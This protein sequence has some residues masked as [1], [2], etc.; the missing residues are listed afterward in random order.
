MNLRGYYNAR[1]HEPFHRPHGGLVTFIRRMPPLTLTQCLPNRC[2]NAHFRPIYPPE[3]IIPAATANLSNSSADPNT[4]RSSKARQR[5]S[6]IC[7]DVAQC[8]P[9]PLQR[10]SS[11]GTDFQW[12]DTNWSISVFF[13]EVFFDW[14]L[15]I[16]IFMAIY[17]TASIVLKVTIRFEPGTCLRAPASSEAG[18]PETPVR[19]TP[20]PTCQLIIWLN[21]V[22]TFTFVLVYAFDVT[23]RYVTSG[24]GRIGLL[25]Q[26]ASLVTHLHFTRSPKR[27]QIPTIGESGPHLSAYPVINREPRITLVASAAGRPVLSCWQQYRLLQRRS[28]TLSEYSKASLTSNEYIERPPYHHSILTALKPRI[29]VLTQG[30]YRP[31]IT[32]QRNLRNN[33]EVSGSVH[34]SS[35]HPIL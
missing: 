24:H 7:N 1:E 22:I 18:H 8:S 30:R 16:T 25:H 28:S 9:L 34:S 10:L 15:A 12:C 11:R 3:S 35:P 31:P 27:C 5:P 4:E 19:H 26:P 32:G 6:I 21:S 20:L 33:H 2:K 23:G 17:Q 13:K 14:T 29:R